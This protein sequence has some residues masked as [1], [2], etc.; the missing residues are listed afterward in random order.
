MKAFLT[1]LLAIN[2]FFIS[3]LSAAETSGKIPDGVVIKHDLAY[4]AEGRKEKLDLYQPKDHPPSGAAPAVVII[5]DG[6]W[7]PILAAARLD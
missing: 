5:Q 4:L 3:P 1:A 7:G 2:W 6:V